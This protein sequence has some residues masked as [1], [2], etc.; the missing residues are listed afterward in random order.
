M[1]TTRIRVGLA[2]LAILALLPL[3]AAPAMARDVAQAEHDRIVAHWTPE[4]IA[5]A[6][7]RDV[8]KH[9][10]T[11]DVAK[12][13]AGKPK[14]PPPGGGGA[15]GG[16]VRGASWN[17][18]GPILAKTGKV[19]FTMDGSDWICSGTVV[20]DGGRANYSMVL[21]AGHCA[22]DETNGTFATNWMFIPAFDTKPTYTCSASLYGCWTAV[23]LVVR[24]EFATAGD[25]NNTAVANDWALAIVGT[26]SKGGQLDATVGSYPLGFSG[27]ATGNKLYAF[28]YPAAGKYHGSDLVYCAG[29]I[30]QDSQA[31]NLTWS[32]PCDM[33]GGSS[34]GPW[35]S[36]F[37]EAT[38]AGTLG[39]LN[40]YG[41]GNTAVMY[42]PKFNSRTQ[43]TYNAALTATTNTKV[44]GS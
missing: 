21:T 6:T 9:G 2:T 26:G 10:S 11:F 39:S 23:A 3:A 13:D 32:M 1:R 44:S 42:G 36:G 8:I 22:I 20:D 29:A 24:N 19:V 38:G 37:V 5:N 34:G 35:L 28:G 15:G 27:V 31:A 18:G 40:S 30:G 33:T 43:A 17:A 7:P 41:Y 12:P 4:R 14:P 25:F 16:S